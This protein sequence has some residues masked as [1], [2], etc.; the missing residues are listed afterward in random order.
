L[1]RYGWSDEEIASMTPARRRAEFLTA[2]E[3]MEDDAK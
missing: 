3:L 1:K 2:M